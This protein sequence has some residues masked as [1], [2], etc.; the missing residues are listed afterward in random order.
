MNPRDPAT[1]TA[2]RR[3]VLQNLHLAGGGH[4]GSCASCIEIILALFASR[5][6]VCREG[7]GDRLLLSKGH[8]SMAL[9]AALSLTSY[10]S[11]PL[12]SF[13]T[14]RSPLQGHPDRKHCDCIDF[15]SGSLGQGLAVGLGMALGSRATGSHVWV[16]LGDGECQEGMIWEAAMLAARYRVNN[17]HAIVDANGEQECGWAHDKTIEQCPVPDD[18]LKWQAF[19][20]DVKEADGH[21]ICGLADWINVRASSQTK[22]PSVLLARTRKHLDPSSPLTGFRRHNAALTDTEFEALARALNIVGDLLNQNAV[23][24]RGTKDDNETT[25]R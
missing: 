2:I 15:S 10:P 4:Y 3:A 24:N 11:L 20:W 13:G 22:K 17:L 16:I 7:M 8:A 12:A 9:Y 5:P 25:R 14:F 6:L 23:F 18:V 21:D 1:A 19:G